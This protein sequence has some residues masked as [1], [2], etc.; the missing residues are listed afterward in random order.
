MPEDLTPEQVAIRRAAEELLRVLQ[1][2]VPSTTA[3]HA[4]TDVQDRHLPR[5]IKLAGS[6]PCTPGTVPATVTVTEEQLTE[7]RSILANVDD[8]SAE[9][10]DAGDQNGKAYEVY[11]DVKLDLAD[12][13]FGLLEQLVAQFA[14][15]HE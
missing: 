1:A 4:V 14:T 9:Y 6:V 2:V 10:E 7:A 13:A 11:E 15:P 5:L 8:N 12:R 3:H